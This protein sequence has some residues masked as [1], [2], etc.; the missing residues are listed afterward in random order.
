MIEPAF[1][2]FASGYGAG[3]AQLLYTRLVADM[4]TPVSAYLKLGF[5]AGGAALLRLCRDPTDASPRDPHLW[6]RDG[7]NHTDRPSRAGA[8]RGGPGGLCPRHRPSGSRGPQALP[9]CSTEYTSAARPSHRRT[10]RIQ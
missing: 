2:S 7:L 9:P 5:I 1:D 10:H 8:G 4:E 3:R 6:L